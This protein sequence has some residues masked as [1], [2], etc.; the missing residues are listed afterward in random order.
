MAEISVFIAERENHVRQAM[1][2]LFEHQ[3]N[4]KFDGEAD[5]AESLLVQVCKRPPDVV[6]IAWDLPGLHPVRFI[7]AVREHCPLV[8]LVSIGVKPEHE[9]PS[10]EAGMDGYLIK[11]LPAQ[12][13]LAGLNEIVSD[14]KKAAKK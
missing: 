14:Q 2:L 7:R 5:D 8:I 6:L 11:Q 13:F 1:K 9:V 4:F 3:P 12:E 10:I